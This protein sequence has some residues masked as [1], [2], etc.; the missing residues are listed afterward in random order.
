[1][2]RQSRIQPEEIGD[3]RPVYALRI[4]SQLSGVPTHS[5]RQYIDKGLILPHKLDSNRHLFSQNDV[6]RLKVINQLLHEKGLNFAG[7]RA[8]MATMPCWAIRNCSPEDRELCLAYSADSDPCWEASVKGRECRNRD[9]R[10][11]EVYRY[12]SE[13]RDLKSVL[14]E[15]I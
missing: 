12:L 11:C 3:S 8:L 1:M 2:E 10:E 4:A 5:I 6:N 13:G 15:R 14:R 9:C 7:I